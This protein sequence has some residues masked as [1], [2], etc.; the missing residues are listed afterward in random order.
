MRMQNLSLTERDFTN[1]GKAKTLLDHNFIRTS[2]LCQKQLIHISPNLS[3]KNGIQLMKI[4][5]A[6]KQP[7]LMKVQE[8]HLV[9][10]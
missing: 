6:V 5:T 3:A 9:K 8:Y 7:H 2:A 10:Q 1:F 4:G